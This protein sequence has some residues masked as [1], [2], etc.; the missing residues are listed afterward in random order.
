MP[1]LPEVEASRRLIEKALLKKKIS[2]IETRPDEIVYKG[3][4]EESVARRFEGDK[5]VAVGRKGKYF[6]LEFAESGYLLAHLGMS[7]AILDVTPDK[8]KAINYHER[9]GIKFDDG[10]GSPTYLKL[11]L[12]AEDGS[13][14][15]LVDPRRLARI[16]TSTSLAHDRSI[17]QL[18]PDAYADLPK[19]ADWEPLLKRRKT[20]IKALLLNQGFVAGI[21]NYLADEIL[22]QAR[23][24][25]ARLANSLS[26]KEA[27]AL[28]EA[29]QDVIK[30]AVKANADYTKFPESWIFHYRWGGARG[31]EMIEGKAIRRDTVGGRTTAWVP[32]LQK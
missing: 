2:H 14:I 1:E 21:G 20:P 25:P 9:K 27:Q 15:A 30:V 3:Q 8:Q 4:P 13:R 31:H 19:I 24:A 29:I 18:G 10:T 7:G 28:H 11:L 17:Q 5:V 26:S 32:E 22:Y 23:I 12:E 6:W 16:W